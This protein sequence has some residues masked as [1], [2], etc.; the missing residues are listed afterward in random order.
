[1]TLHKPT[2]NSPPPIEVINEI[3]HPVKSCLPAATHVASQD[4][5][6]PFAVHAECRPST[7]PAYVSENSPL[8][9]QSQDPVTVKARVIRE[10]G[11]HHKAVTQI[12]QNEAKTVCDSSMRSANA[13]SYNPAR[14]HSR[15]GMLIC[16][17]AFMLHYHLCK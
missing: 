10:E 7:E 15:S 14:Y 11:L 3:Q 17:F 6:D 13:G 2:V 12:T 1:M 16:F 4:V 8:L 9:P 5:Q